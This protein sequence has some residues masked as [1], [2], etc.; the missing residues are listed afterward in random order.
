MYEFDYVNLVISYNFMDREITTFKTLENIVNFDIGNHNFKELA[1]LFLTAMNDWPNSN[2]TEISE[3]IV[4]LRKFIGSPITLK[5]IN[6]KNSLKLTESNAWK[7]ESISSIS[8]LIQKAEKTIQEDDFDKVI[9]KILEYYNLE[10]S[11][12]DFLAELDYLKSDKGGRN[13][14]ALSGYRPQVKF[15][16][17]QMITSGQQTFIDKEIVFPGEN[18]IAKIKILSPQFFEKE[19]FK[20]LQ[21]EFREGARLIGTGKVLN[22][23]NGKLQKD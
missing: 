18:V 22:V 5:K 17:S 14:G 9:A 7:L 12:I 20:G 15:H 4:E 3:F 16:F 1:K 13:T 6:A 11:L 19:L 21:F 23:I 10:F 2:K 8:E